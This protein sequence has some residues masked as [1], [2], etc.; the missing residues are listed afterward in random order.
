MLGV[1]AT[2]AIDRLHSDGTCG[3]HVW[4]ERLRVL[5]ASLRPLMPFPAILE[6]KLKPRSLEDTLRP[7]RMGTMS[8]EVGSPAMDLDFELQNVGRW[9]GNLSISAR[10]KGV[11]HISVRR[12]WRRFPARRRISVIETRKN[13]QDKNGND[14]YLQRSYFMHRY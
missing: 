3:L 4:E 8:A 14:E 11:S 13:E 5:K 2:V 9:G 7:R 1:G 6:S 12:I 10:A